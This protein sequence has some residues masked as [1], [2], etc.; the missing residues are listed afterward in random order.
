MFALLFKLVDQGVIDSTNLYLRKDLHT[1]DYHLIM[2][3]DALDGHHF[4]KP[5]RGIVLDG[6][7]APEP[8][9]W[10]KP[11]DLFSD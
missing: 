3:N 7:P 6:A 2:R 9:F 8:L 1:D 10:E 5:E 11:E 4:I